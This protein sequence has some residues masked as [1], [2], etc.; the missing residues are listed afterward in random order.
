MSDDNHPAGVYI[1]QENT[2]YTGIIST[3]VLNDYAYDNYICG[4]IKE[5]KK[6][7]DIGK[8]HE[9]PHAYQE[10]EKGNFTVQKREIWLFNSVGG[11]N[12][13]V[14]KESLEIKPQKI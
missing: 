10:Y 13:V 4:A 7:I 12:L 14:S 2:L 11:G 1:P 6:P 9:S 8:S 5:E 3:M